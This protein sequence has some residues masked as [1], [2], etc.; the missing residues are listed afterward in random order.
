MMHETNLAGVLISPLVA[1]IAVAVVL[2]LPVRWAFEHFRLDRW[3]YN[4]PLAEAAVFVC[5]LGALV[6][7]L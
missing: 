4:S 3:T 7:W 5:S 6:V 1:Y 2:W